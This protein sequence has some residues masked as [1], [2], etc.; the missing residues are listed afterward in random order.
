MNSFEAKVLGNINNS[1]MIVRG[2]KVLIA[3]SGGADSMTLLYLLVALRKE[4]EVD[5]AI[6]HLNHSARGIESDEDAHFVANLGK[7]GYKDLY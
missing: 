7:S 3:V 6:G 4:L 2:D 1:G 5:L